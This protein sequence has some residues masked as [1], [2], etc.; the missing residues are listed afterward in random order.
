M[1]QRNFFVMTVQVCR[2]ENAYLV[3]EMAGTGSALPTRSLDGVVI[4]SFNNEYFSEY[5][6]EGGNGG[7][8]PTCTFP[9][10][11]IIPTDVVVSPVAISKHERNQF[12]DLEI[13]KASCKELE[14]V[15]SRLEF[16]LQCK[17][18]Q[19]D[20]LKREIGNLKKS[21]TKRVSNGSIRGQCPNVFYLIT[22]MYCPLLRVFFFEFF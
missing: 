8:L 9:H 19:L 6:T 14:G 1:Q 3:R 4:P 13:A 5:K 15:V 12:S 18:T 16:D 17:D 21:L 10:K 7:F 20:V 22:S 11:S 2:E